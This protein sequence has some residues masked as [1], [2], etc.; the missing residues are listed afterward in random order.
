MYSDYIC[1]AVM[2]FCFIFLFH[3]FI[4]Y[5][6]VGQAELHYGFILQLFQWNRSRCVLHCWTSLFLVGD[7]M[8]KSFFFLSFFN[9]VSPP[10][11]DLLHFSLHVFHILFQ[12]LRS[13]DSFGLKKM[14]VP[15]TVHHQSNVRCGRDWFNAALAHVWFVVVSNEM[16][17]LLS[18]DHTWL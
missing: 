14:I 1:F 12:R 7:L 9:S 4:S 2:F 11:H 8:W 15:S 6:K 3:D 16:F 17:F 18:H 5:K 13:D 10:P